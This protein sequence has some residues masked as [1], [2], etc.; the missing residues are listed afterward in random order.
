MALK[1][2]KTKATTII[3]TISLVILLLS[4]PIIVP[5]VYAGECSTQA[6]SSC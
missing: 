4:S 2:I 5:T 1:A 6:S 3:L